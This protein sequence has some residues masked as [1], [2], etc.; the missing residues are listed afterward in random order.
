MC[1]SDG[2]VMAAVVREYTHGV[3]DWFLPDGMTE[4]R[5]FSVI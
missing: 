4:W 2:K 1:H 3:M 5:M